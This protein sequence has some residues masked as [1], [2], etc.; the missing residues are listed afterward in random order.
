MIN[1]LSTQPSTRKALLLV[2][3]LF[4]PLICRADIA[5]GLGIVF[6]FVMGYF[7]L[8]VVLFILSVISYL[9]QI[10][11]IA[12]LC[13]ALAVLLGMTAIIW[14]GMDMFPG[15]LLVAGVA[16]FCFWLAGIKHN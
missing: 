7:A 14:L 11:M 16:S 2:L 3:L 15:A 8:F 12:V 13:K 6:N 4:S 5:D 1:L 10:R 9:S